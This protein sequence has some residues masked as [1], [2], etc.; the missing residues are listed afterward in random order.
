MDLGLKEKLSAR[1][2]AVLGS[3]DASAGPFMPKGALSSAVPTPKSGRMTRGMDESFLAT[4]SW[5]GWRAGLRRPE[6]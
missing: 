6:V 1:P 4:E 3:F 2:R 5:G